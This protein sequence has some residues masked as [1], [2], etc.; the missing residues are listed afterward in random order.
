MHALFMVPRL[1]VALVVLQLGEAHGGRGARRCGCKRRLR[2]PPAAPPRRAA[3][4]GHSAGD[5]GAGVGGGMG[6]GGSGTAEADRAAR[7]PVVDESTTFATV[8][9]L[10]ALSLS[11]F[12]CHS[13]RDDA[14]PSVDPFALVQ[15]E[16]SA[17]NNDVCDEVVGEDEVLTCASQHF[18]G[19]GNTRAGK[20]VRPVIV[21]LM[22]QATAM[23]MA[24][25]RGGGDEAAQQQQQQQQSEGAAAKHRQLAA[26][27]EM[28]HTASLVHDD[29]LDAADTRRG[30][31]AVHKLYS[32]KAAV[33]RGDFLLARASVALARLGMPSVTQEMAKSLEALVQGEIMQLQS[34]AE[35]RLSLEYYLTKSY[36]K[37]ASLMA[38]SCKSAA[39]LSEHA[40]DSEVAVAAEKFGYHF[41]LAFQ[42]I[43]DLLD[44]TG[45]SDTLGKPGLQ[46][47][48]LG[49]STAPVLYGLDEK[50]EL[51]GL[52][53]E[54]KFEE[55]GDV[56]LACELVLASSGLQ[57]TKELAEFHAQAAVDACCSLP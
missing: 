40:R 13:V 1:A 36:C 53:V 43:D 37:T 50:P 51:K 47:M 25:Q 17:L 15:D 12:R 11:Q 18:F 52:V 35:E 22:G 19:A 16:I 49:L 44:F 42:V 41:G 3:W 6:G 29:V 7:Q 23:A 54:R 10:N 28:I 30:G 27:T 8:R 32:T 14:A 55:P 24:A 33:L 38:F 2:V 34:S 39:L 9:S 21:C 56:Q 57:R 26:I 4:A 48:A 5:R 46:D 45:T 31:S 20:R